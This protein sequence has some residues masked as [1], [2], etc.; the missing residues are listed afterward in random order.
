MPKLPALTARQ[1]IRALKK[2]GFEEDRQSGS[3]LILLHPESKA[4]T[5][6]PVHKGRTIK[7]PLLHAIIR[8][9]R[10]SVEQFLRQV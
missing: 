1:V 4:R 8:D 6:V 9:A 3:H 5:V 2:L 7:G 10:V